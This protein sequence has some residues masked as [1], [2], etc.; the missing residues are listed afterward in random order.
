MNVLRT[1]RQKQSKQ[2]SDIKE[3]RDINFYLDI[4]PNFEISV[5]DF[6]SLALARL[7]VSYISVII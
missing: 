4:P 6:E 1:N 7:K 5:D 2:T 3:K